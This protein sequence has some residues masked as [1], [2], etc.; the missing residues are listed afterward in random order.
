M[1]K[2]SFVKDALILFAITFILG[3]ALSV[4]EQLTEEP[5]KK[6]NMAAVLDSYKI[7]C[8]EFADYEDKTEGLT[9]DYTGPAKLD[10]A[11][12][13]KDASGKQVGY[14]IT[15]ISTGFGGNIK[16][17]TGFDNDLKIT[18]ISYPETLSETPGL[19][20]KVTDKDLFINNYI[21]KTD[22]DITDGYLISGASISSTAVREGLILAYKCCKS[23]KGGN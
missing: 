13:A 8:P 14:I 17:V 20:M 21:G 6:A 9:T 19:G 11:L 23:M 18:G 4:V 3:I 2:S 22:T 10:S 5:I 12:I 15:T 16:T 7:V 1:K